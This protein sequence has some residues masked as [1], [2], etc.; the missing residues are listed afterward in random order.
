M[1]TLLFKHVNIVDVRNKQ[2]IPSTDILV[3]DGIIRSIAKD[4]HESADEI[5]DGEGK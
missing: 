4:I 3:K 5:I 1:G 2:I